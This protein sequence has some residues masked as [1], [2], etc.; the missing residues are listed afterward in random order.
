MSK[1]VTIDRANLMLLRIQ[2]FKDQTGKT[3]VILRNPF[4]GEI[5]FVQQTQAD[6]IRSKEAA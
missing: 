3:P 6:L 4:T 1:K 2:A 5:I